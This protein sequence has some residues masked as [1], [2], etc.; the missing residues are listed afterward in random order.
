MLQYHVSFK[1]CQV[2]HSKFTMTNC[3]HLLRVTLRLIF[4]RAST[5]LSINKRYA[6]MMNQWEAHKIVLFEDIRL[7]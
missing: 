7:F 3:Q 4:V 1:P 2:Q 6:Y 5:S